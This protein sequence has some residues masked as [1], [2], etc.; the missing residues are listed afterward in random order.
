LLRQLLPKLAKQETEGLFDY[1]IVIVD[2]D[3]FE[4]A[5]QTVESYARQSKIAISYNVEPVQ[6][7]ALARNKAIE[8]AKGDFIAFIDDDEF[9]QRDWLTC[10]YKTYKKYN[11]DGVLGP[12]LPYF[13]A[14][15]PKWILRGKF[16]ERPTH[17]T[18]TILQWRFTRTGNVLFSA[19]I[20]QLN[21][22]QFNP[23]LGS[24]G[25]D[26]DF[27][28]RMIEKGHKFV[29]C[30]DAPVHEIISPHRWKESFM[31]RRALLRGQGS[32]SNPSYSKWGVVTSLLAVP[33][34]TISLPF[35][36][37]IGKHIFMKYFIKNCDH[38]G[39]LLGFIGFIVIKEKYITE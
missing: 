30:N 22:R 20:L 34:Y 8:N 26:R 18:G 24:G 19:H 4:S 1:S 23:K 36:L 38:L 15:P 28:R 3:K 35:L 32:L 16:F 25:E 29:W 13:E 6:N 33:V 37:I 27:F 14:P 5:R 9:P 17:N 39:R 12:V 2:N 11:A 10:L 7:I 31:L 21:R